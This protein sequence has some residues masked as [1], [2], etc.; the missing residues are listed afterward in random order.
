MKTNI[1]GS[2]LLAAAAG[3]LASGCVVYTRPYRAEVVV[4]APAPPPAEVVVATA[5]PPAPAYA[6]VVTPSPGVDFV[7][8]PGAYFWT[9]AR[10][11]WNVG[12]WDRPPRRGM[13]W[14]PHHYEFRGGRQVFVAGHWR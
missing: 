12:H 6:D 2:L 4:A 14:V 8:I 9:G 1:I 5:P 3:F 13:V 11:E 7:W 10:W